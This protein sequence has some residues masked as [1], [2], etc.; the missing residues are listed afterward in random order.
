MTSIMKMA[1]F[2]PET[3]AAAFG[4]EVVEIDDLRAVVL[5]LARD[6]CDLCMSAEVEISAA[7]LANVSFDGKFER[8]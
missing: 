2:C 6:I 7:P 1:P 8:I 5:V 3:F 4:A